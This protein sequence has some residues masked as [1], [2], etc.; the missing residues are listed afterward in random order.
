[1][2]TNN[3]TYRITILE[4]DEYHRDRGVFVLSL[5][6]KEKGQPCDYALRTNIFQTAFTKACS[7]ISKY[8]IGENVSIE[9]VDLSDKIS[10]DQFRG[11]VRSWGLKQAIYTYERIYNERG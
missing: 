11:D 3:T 4:R 6:S 7:L 8:H 10:L 9:V 5:D 2:T 1:M